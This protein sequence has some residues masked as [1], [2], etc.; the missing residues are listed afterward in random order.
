M[1]ETPTSLD[2]LN[3]NLNQFAVSYAR[4]YLGVYDHQMGKLVQTMN[5]AENFTQ[6]HVNILESHPNIDILGAGSDNGG[7][8]LLELRQSKIVHSVHNAHSSAVSSL[9]FDRNGFSMY[10]GGHDGSLKVWD[11]RQLSDMVCV[12]EYSGHQPKYDEYIHHLT[13]HPKL[14]MLVSSGADGKITVFDTKNN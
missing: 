9:C 5:L 1:Q 13:L 3:T 2:W 12:N 6:N 8:S 10:T 11:L 7:I 4:S 14:P